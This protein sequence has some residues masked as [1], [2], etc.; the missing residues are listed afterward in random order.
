MPLEHLHSVVTFIGSSTFKTSMPTNVT[1]GTGFIR[2]I[3]S[4]RQPVFSETE[5]DALLQ[6]LQTDRRAATLATHREHVQN[7]KRRKTPNSQDR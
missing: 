3:K 5:V 6:A 7:L 2:Y 4:F 1:Q